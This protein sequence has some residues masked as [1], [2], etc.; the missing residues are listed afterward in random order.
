MRLLLDLRYRLEYAA[1]RLLIGLIRLFPLDRAADFSAWLLRT[2]APHTR[3]QRRALANLEIAFPEKTP[4]EREAITRDMWDNLGRVAAEMMQIDRILA[5]APNRISI[6]NDYFVKRY[7]GK[8]GRIVI[9]GMH[10]GNWEIGAWPLTLADANLTG[11]YRLV[12]NP[13]VDD[14]LTRMRSHLYPSGLVSKGRAAVHQSGYDTARR[15][16]DNLRDGGRLGFLADRFDRQGLEVPFFGHQAKS[17]SFPAMLAR[18]YGARMWIGR[19]M[20]VGAQSRFT[21]GFR[22]LR[23]PRSADAEAD[24]QEVTAAIQAQ[25]E[26]W[27]R[28]APGQ[29]MWTNRRFS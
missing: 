9:I 22:E 21:V 6:E 10:Y 19:C 13:Y 5:D 18:R 1:L 4:A 17:S 27:I 14:Y 12:K 15:L 8:M 7:K 26:E 25:F 20:R 29:Y 2:V 3:R 28:E 16:A 23:I 24:I 11:V